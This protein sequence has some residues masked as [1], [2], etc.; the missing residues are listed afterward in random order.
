MNKIRMFYSLVLSSAFL[1]LTLPM[2]FA[3]NAAAVEKYV[4]DVIVMNNAG[5]GV[6]GATV[7]LKKQVT[8][9]FLQVKT[10]YT[11]A[12]GVKTFSVKSGA[13]YKV[14][15]YYSGVKGTGTFAKP[16]DFD[17]SLAG[18]QSKAKSG[19]FTLNANQPVSFQQGAAAT[20]GP[21]GKEWKGTNGTAPII[22]P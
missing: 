21:V 19:A 6:K 13:T 17:G 1:L 16:F 10:G 5:A 3:G 20:N 22:T 9:G 7:N 15:V 14:F 4:I 8:G 2:I 11:D 12:S 18:Q